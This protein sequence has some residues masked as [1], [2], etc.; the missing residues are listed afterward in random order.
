MRSLLIA[1][2]AARAAKYYLR[3]DLQESSLNLGVDSVKRAHEYQVD[4]LI[5]WLNKLLGVG[6]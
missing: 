2:M 1:E 3:Y 6:S 4:L 5:N